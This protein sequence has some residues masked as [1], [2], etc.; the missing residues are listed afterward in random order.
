MT[1]YLLDTD[2]ASR[3]MRA[4]RH[5]VNAMRRAGATSIA[6][7]T[8]T[9]SEL[10]FGAR[11]R[12]DAPAI[13][14]AVRA[15]LARVTVQAWDDVAAEHHAEIRAAAKAAGRSAGAFDIMIAAHARALRATL[16]TSDKAIGRLKIDGLDVVSWS[17][18][19]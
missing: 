5:T 3:L 10:V 7:S 19:R 1:A 2:T 9:Q 16:V 13:M 17:G 18:K 8:V 12:S 15:F 4:D 6:I 11:L 14:A